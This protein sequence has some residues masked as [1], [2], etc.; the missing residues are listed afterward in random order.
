MALS[1]IVGVVIYLVNMLLKQIYYIYMDNLFSSPNLFCALREVGYGAIGT[2]R[3]NC[4]I[5]KELKV[6]KGKDNIDALGFKYNKVKLIPIINGLL[7]PRDLFIYISLI[8]SSF[9]DCLNRLEG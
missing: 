8:N 6:I 2:A 3:P 1:N 4:N 5:T 7:R 9:L